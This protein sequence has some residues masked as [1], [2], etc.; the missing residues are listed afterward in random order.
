[1]MDIRRLAAEA[2]YDWAL[3]EIA[4]YFES[5]P[6]PGTPEADRFNVLAE[7]IAT[8]ENQYWPIEAPDHPSPALTP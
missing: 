1:M 2:D 7:L 8:Y 6:K 5:V 4:R 3:A